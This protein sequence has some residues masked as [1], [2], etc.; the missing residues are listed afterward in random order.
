MKLNC[1]E[2]KKCGREP[3]GANYQSGRCPAV[4]AYNLTGIHGGKR[5]GR[6]CWVVAGT[7]CGDQ[8]QGTFAKK[9][10]SCEQCDFYKQVRDEEQGH[11]VLSLDILK[12][13]Q[14]NG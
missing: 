3:G 11:Y 12:K 13:M 6:A 10:S 1:W 14:G 9:F 7:L 5:G 2:F 8:I 4:E